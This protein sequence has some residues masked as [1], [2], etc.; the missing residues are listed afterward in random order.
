MTLTFIQDSRHQQ[1][2]FKHRTLWENILEV[3]LLKPVS[4]FK[5]NT[6]WMVLRWSSFKIVSSDP[7]Y[8]QD[9]YHQWTIHHAVQNGLIIPPLRRSGG[10][11]GLRLSV[12]PSVLPSVRNKIFRTT[13]LGNYKSDLLEI[14]YGALARWT[15]LCDTFPDLSIIY[16]LFD[17][18]FCLFNVMRLYKIFRHI[19]LYNYKSQV[20]NIW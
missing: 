13:F 4:Q 8:I 15:V 16:F 3:F 17:G 9:G 10:Y 12:R 2:Y 6:A 1:T 14:W 11:T 7:A 19:F 20:V 5:A 18:H